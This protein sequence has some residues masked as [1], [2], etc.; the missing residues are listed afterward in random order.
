MADTLFG[1]IIDNKY[2]ILDVVA[3]GAL[4][5]VYRV[6]QLDVE[7]QRLREVALKVLRSPLAQDPASEQ[8]FLKEV[9]IA[10]RLDNPHLVRVHDSGR[11]DDG[12]L[13]FTME[14]VEGI[15]LRELLR[16]EGSLPLTQTIDVVGQI[17]EAL[18]EAHNPPNVIVH[19]DLKPANIFIER[20]E[21]KDW[22]K[23]SDF[24][25]A[26]NVGENI[27]P[28]GFIGTPRYAAPEQWAEKPVNERSD[29]YSLGITMYE[30]LTGAPPFSGS[31]DGLRHDHFYSPPP[32]LP[33]TIPDSIRHLVEQLLEKDPNARPVN[34]LSFKQSL[35]NAFS[36]SEKASSHQLRVFLCHSSRDK[37]AVRDLY[38]R[39]KADGIAPWLDEIDILPGQEWE[40][41]IRRAVYESD[42]VLVCLSHAA[43]TRRGFV[44]KEITFALDVADEQPE[45]TIYLIP[46]KL[47][48]CEVPERLNRWQWVN[49][50]QEG[51]YEKLL[52]SLRVRERD[53]RRE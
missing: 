22:V 17:C 48:E 37:Q 52:E 30:M 4:S 43:M 24:G 41:E 26:L 23:I 8:F 13:Y 29:L 28:V 15:T 32:P 44:H 45:R 35:E 2:R 5:E 3:R 7:G 25:I 20:R 12:S 18:A 10:A 49:Y 9:R 14:F 21:G 6:E 19:R 42:V 16:R 47:E 31:I 51:G 50:F 1:Q 27:D 38:K 34:A 40:S 36:E 39:L 53:T 46:A 33:E 11:M